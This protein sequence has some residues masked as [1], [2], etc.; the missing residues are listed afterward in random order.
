MAAISACLIVIKN[1]HFES[2]GCISDDCNI[3]FVVILKINAYNPKK[4]ENKYFKK[5]AAIFFA[6]LAEITLFNNF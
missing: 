3:Q 2:R 4:N 6:K 1:Y 5:M